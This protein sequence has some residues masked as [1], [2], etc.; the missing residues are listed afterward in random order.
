MR[1]LFALENN[2]AS[3]STGN[4]DQPYFASNGAPAIDVDP[5]IV[6]DFAA[7]V[8]TR[9]TGTK[10]EREALSGKKIFEG[11][12]FGDT[13]LKAEF[14]V[15]DGSWKQVLGDTGWVTPSLGSGWTNESGNPVQYR[16]RNGIVSNRGRASTTGERSQMFVYGNG[17][18]PEIGAGA[19]MTFIIDATGPAR[20]NVISTGA[21]TMLTTGAL[22]NVS[23]ANIRFDAA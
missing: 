11:L 21:L 6:S 8:G 9:R 20:A 16:K 23:I 18:L 19:N 10:A 17:F 12:A 3:E 2:M 13:S 7:E 15:I 4:R 22:T 14:K 1:G 5:G